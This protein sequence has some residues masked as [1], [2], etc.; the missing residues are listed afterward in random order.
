M[1]KA[2]LSLRAGRR[3]ISRLLYFLYERRLGAQL[4]R[5]PVPAH[6]GIILDGNRRH[7]RQRGVTDPQAIYDLGAHKLDAV[8][9]WCGE[10]AV[11][12]VTLWV[13]STENFGRPADQVSGILAAVES[14]VRALATDPQIHSRRV[15]VRAIG[16]LE[17]LPP[18]TIA[19]IRAAET[20]TAAYDGMTLTI[21]VAYGGHEEI[22][23]AVRALLRKE[24]YRGRDLEAAIEQV[25]PAAIGENLYLAALPNPDLIIRTSGELRLSGFLLWQSAYSEFHFTDVNWPDFRKIDFMR[26]LRA[27]QQRQRRFGE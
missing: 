23:D 4:D 25:T 10:Y 26:A 3:A 5:G 27:Y 12:A 21:A 20:A 18:S 2:G 16:R 17:L 6:I 22:V 14:K 15:R 13:L 1:S 8:L 19:A 7:G 9:D 11:L 24:H